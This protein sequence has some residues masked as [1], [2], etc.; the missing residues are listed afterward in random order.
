MN[1][2]PDRAAFLKGFRRSLPLWA[3]AMPVALVY[4]VSAR[5]AGFGAFEILAM[6][7]LIYSATT[8]LSLVA[9]LAAGTP[10]STLML[11]ALMLNIHHVLYGM[12]LPEHVPLTRTQRR[13]AAFFL[14]DSVYGL[15]MAEENADA[16]FL[17][18]AASSLY[19]AWNF[20]TLVGLLAGQVFINPAA[21]HLDFITPLTFAVL[22]AAALNSRRDT[23]TAAVAVM[24]AL[25]CLVSGAGS[26]TLPVAVITASLFGAWISG[27]NRLKE[28]V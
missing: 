16:A 22:L 11:T 3:G 26:L 2:M 14:T 27:Q 15:T 1:M 23:G 19:F 8:Q 5:A 17:A 12:S 7:L 24:I 28:A 18:G 21:L 10:L 25:V 13:I 6:S 9:L 20:F 4:A